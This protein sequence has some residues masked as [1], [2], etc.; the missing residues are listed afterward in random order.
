M[1]T[2]TRRQRFFDPFEQLNVF[3]NQLDRFFP[4]MKEDLDEELYTTQWTPPADVME[5]KDAIIIRTELPGFT[6]KEIN[7]EFEN[8]ILTLQGERHFEKATAEKDYRRIERTYGKFLRYFTLP[9]NVETTKIV[10]SYTN[11]LLE[12]HIPKKEEA[13]AK[14]I[15]VEVK[16]KLPVAA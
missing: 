4:A 1:N 3:R 8:G 14:T 13:K 10:A 6:E 9:P 15:H 12:L 5:S 11:G 16:K 7:V 2:P